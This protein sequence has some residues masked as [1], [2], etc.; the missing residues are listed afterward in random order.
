MS[1]LSIKSCL[2]HTEVF[3]SPL[4]SAGVLRSGSCRTTPC[5]CSQRMLETKRTT[6]SGV[7]VKCWRPGGVC[8]RPV[9]AEGPDCWTPETSSASS[10]WCVTSCSGWRMSS[11]SSRRRR[12]PGVWFWP[13]YALV[14]RQYWKCACTLVK[15]DS[16]FFVGVFETEMAHNDTK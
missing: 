2:L 6:S 14:R 9:R 8:W 3:H 11:A 15:R 10:V 4:T 13:A 12:S 5:A 16:L 1:A 7:R